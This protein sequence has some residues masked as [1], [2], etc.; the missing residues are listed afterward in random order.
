MWIIVQTCPFYSEIPK[1]FV[2]VE[3]G[4]KM[5]RMREKKRGSEKISYQR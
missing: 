2:E 5:K 4:I 3:S 1:Y